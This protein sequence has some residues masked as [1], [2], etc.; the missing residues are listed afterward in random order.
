M[1][2]YFSRLQNATRLYWDKPAIR[3][4]R[5]ESFTYGQMATQIARFHIFF[6][7]CGLKQGDKIA[8]CAKNTA[9]MALSFLAVNTS[10]KVVVPILSDFTPDSVNWLVDHSESVILF[11]NNDIWDK[12]DISKMPA[13]KAVI[14]VN[15]FSLIYGNDEVKEA[16]A[17]ISAAFAAKFP[18]GFTA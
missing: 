12:L 5:G 10:G 9:R 18:L 15:D 8:I 17:G 6:D 11:T 4:F 2:H 13:I 14:S 1:E 16:Y 3:N 7:A